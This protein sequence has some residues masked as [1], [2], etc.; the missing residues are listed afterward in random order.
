MAFCESD[1]FENWNWKH[2]A[3][4]AAVIL[5][6]GGVIAVLVVAFAVVY[7]PK[8]TADDAILQRFALAPGSPVENSTV[9]YNITATLSLRNPNIYRAIRYAPMD[10]SFSFNGS[11]FGADWAAAALLRR[12]SGGLAAAAR[13]GAARRRP[14]PG[15][16]RI[17]PTD[18]AFYFP[19]D[20]EYLPCFGEYLSETK[21]DCLS[22]LPSAGF[23]LPDG[24]Y[25]LVPQTQIYL[26][27]HFISHPFIS[28]S[29]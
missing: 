6:L 21:S 22:D 28:L 23:S 17:F 29:Q 14:W 10:T 2:F 26:Q 24:S 9:S 3:I 12:G 19:A 11:R 7:P 27:H 20:P 15:E 25:E 4:W 18:S 8:A 13:C 5:V 1:I 16:S